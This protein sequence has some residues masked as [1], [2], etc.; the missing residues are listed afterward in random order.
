MSPEDASSTLNSSLKNI[1]HELHRNPFPEVQNP[2]ET[3]K[4]ASVALIIR[5]RPSSNHLRGENDTTGTEPTDSFTSQLDHFFARS[6][7][8]PGEPEV[9][10]IRRASRQGDPWTGHIA[11]PGG[12]RDPGDADDFSAAVRETW[13][14]VGIDLTSDHTLAAGNLPQRLVTASWGRKV[15]VAHFSL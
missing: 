2:P 10:F 15:Y 11:L 14:E 9:L 7:V 12:R 4:R 5:I 6:W 3:Q 13:E 8:E 1:L